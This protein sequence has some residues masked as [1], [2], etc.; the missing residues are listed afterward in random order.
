VEQGSRHLPFAELPD[1]ND[2]LAFLCIIILDVIEA[3]FDVFPE[4]HL[5]FA[6]G[7]QKSEGLRGTTRLDG[8]KPEDG[9]SHQK[10]SD[11]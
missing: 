3:F 8:R 5:P 7:G 1:A 9:L 6:Q 11:A 2:I 4:L 10:E